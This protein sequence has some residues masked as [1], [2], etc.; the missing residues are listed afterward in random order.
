MMG[1]GAA[2]R[3]GLTVE[4]RMRVLGVAAPMII[5]AVILGA[6]SAAHAQT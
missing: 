5:S 1:P 6:M 3:C 4:I 2:G